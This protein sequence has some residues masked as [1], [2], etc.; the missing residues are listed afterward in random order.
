LKA[1]LVL[2]QTPSLIKRFSGIVHRE[3]DGKRIRCHGDYHLGQLLYTGKDFVI[4]DFEGEPGRPLSERIIKRSPLQDVAGMIRSFHYASQ[5]ALSRKTVRSEDLAPLRSWA[6][7]WTRAVTASFLSRYLEGVKGFG[8][9]PSNA[10][11]LSLLLNLLIVD[12]AFYEVSYELNNRPDWIGT[13]LEGLLQIMSEE[14][15]HS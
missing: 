9:L 10:E 13:P 5:T 7:L 11:D 2:S 14:V 12:K 6:A 3:L 8:L 15:R 1:N 4:V